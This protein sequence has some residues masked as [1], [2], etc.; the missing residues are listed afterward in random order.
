MRNT[1]FISF[2]LLAFTVNST[3]QRYSINKYR[4]DYHQYIPEYGDLYNPLISGVCSFIVP[5][6]GQMYCGEVGRGLAFLGGYAGFSVV[7]V[8]GMAQIYT[9]SLN[10][11]N[12]DSGYSRNSNAGVGTM[13]FGFGGMVAVG[14]W[15]IVD[16][17][18][19]AKVNNMYIRDLRRTSSVNFEMAPYVEHLTINNQ[20]ATPLGMTMRIKF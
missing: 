10:Y 12:S 16:A 11:F 13:L 7:A 8:V 17:V 18:N 6:L 19:V 20:T 3:A 1:L 14:I 9:S 5:G 2:I 15:S 4:Y